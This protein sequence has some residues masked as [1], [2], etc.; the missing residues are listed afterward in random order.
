VAEWLRQGPAKP[1]TWVR[2]PSSPPEDRDAC[3]SD[4]PEGEV[5]LYCRIMTGDSPRISP[6]EDPSPEVAEFIER[7]GLKG[8]NGKPINIFG[9]LAHHPDLLRRW[10][11]FAG[12]I[13]AKNTLSPR[14]REIL[15]LRAGVRCGS[16]YEFAQHAQIAKECDMSD[17][18]IQATKGPV[19]EWPGS[20]LEKA[21][22]S[23]ADELHAR[24]RI[25]DATWAKLSEAYSTEQLLDI[26]FT[27]GQY[28]L[29]SMLLNTAGV[30]VDEGIPDLL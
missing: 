20:D 19:D 21:L 15:I 23:A 22:L 9:T 16:R 4:P 27:V 28:T 8:P 14:D 18:E 11:V 30:V 26:V 5:S 6:I 12:H 7:A 3:G 10:M 29:V 24:Q 17:G 1:C 13:M 2:F 25:D